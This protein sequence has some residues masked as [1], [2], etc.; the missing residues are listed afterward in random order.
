MPSGF[1]HDGT[2]QNGTSRTL[3]NLGNQSLTVDGTDDYVAIGDINANRPLFAVGEVYTSPS[4]YA[5]KEREQAA[6]IT[7]AQQRFLETSRA[8]IELYDLAADPHELVNIADRPENQ[9]IVRDLLGRMQQLRRE[10]NDP[11]LDK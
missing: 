9:T 5:L 4:W 8:E 7:P 3:S 6:T 1:G 2:L 11:Y 10:T